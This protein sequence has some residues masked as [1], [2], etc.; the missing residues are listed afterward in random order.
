[1]IMQVFSTYHLGSKE[2][3]EKCAA[4]LQREVQAKR[5]QPLSSEDMADALSF[6][7]K[8]DMSKS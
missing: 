5:W 2:F 3:K 1:M 7:K 6:Y 4:L 8:T